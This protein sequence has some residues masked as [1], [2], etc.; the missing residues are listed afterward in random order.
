MKQENYG[1]IKLPRKIQDDP[2][3]PVNRRAKL[4]L[5]EK[6]VD[7]SFLVSFTDDRQLSLNGKIIVYGK[8]EKPLS[9]RFLAE[10][11]HCKKDSALAT[12]RS[13]ESR[14]LISIENRQGISVV[15]LLIDEANSENSEAQPDRVNDQ[16]T[17]SKPDTEPDA[18]PDADPDKYNN[19][20]IEE[21]KKEKNSQ[22]SVESPLSTNEI[23]S[24]L[25]NYLIKRLNTE[26]AESILSNEKLLVESFEKIKRF[27]AGEIIL[28][29]KNQPI[30]DFAAWLATADK[31]VRGEIAE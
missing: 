11:W 15:K 25:R 2:L 18:E 20:I 9:A 30:K 16:K 21:L 4:T 12:L 8:N 28:D 7:L 13:L 5:F 10:R 19:G 27:A 24:H 23:K 29:R 6:F 31:N 3:Y 22:Y 17:D 14:H 1:F 26:R